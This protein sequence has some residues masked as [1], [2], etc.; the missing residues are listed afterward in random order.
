MSVIPRVPK[1]QFV[2]KNKFYLK[3]LILVLGLVVREE[4]LKGSSTASIKRSRLR[5]RRLKYR[6]IKTK[7]GSVLLVRRIKVKNWRIKDRP[8]ISRSIHWLSTVARKFSN[9]LA[10]L[11]IARLPLRGLVLYRFR[12]RLRKFRKIVSYLLPQ[13]IQQIKSQPIKLQKVRCALQACLPP[14]MRKNS[15]TLRACQKRIPER[16]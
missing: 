2:L 13:K 3:F 11:P 8:K 6:W 12:V 1:N 14:S 9:R 5:L 4:K 7:R 16:R 15:W 10:G